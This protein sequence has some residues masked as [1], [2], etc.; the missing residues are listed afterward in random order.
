MICILI[1]VDRGEG[2]TMTILMRVGLGEN[3]ATNI[4]II[5]GAGDG[6]TFSDGKQTAKDGDVIAADK[7]GIG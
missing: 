4:L 1:L 6:K 7:L 5:P 2:L 3:Q